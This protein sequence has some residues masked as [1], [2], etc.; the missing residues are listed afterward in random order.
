VF[1][2]RKKKKILKSEAS[3]VTTDCPDCLFQQRANLEKESH[4]YEK[5]WV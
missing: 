2:R 4:P 3:L 1:G 5:R